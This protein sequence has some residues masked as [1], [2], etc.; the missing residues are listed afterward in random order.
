MSLLSRQI[1]LT[2][3]LYLE[4]IGEESVLRVS[5]HIMSTLRIKYEYLLRTL[6]VLCL[7]MTLLELQERP[8]RGGAARQLISQLT[9]LTCYNCSWF[10]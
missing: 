6:S 10:H 8:G 4:E 9:R 5:A 3:I 7:E 1:T 2:E